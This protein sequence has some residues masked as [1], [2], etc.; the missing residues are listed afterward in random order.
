M[1]DEL[2]GLIKIE[3]YETSDNKFRID[4]NGMVLVD[5]NVYNELETRKDVQNPASEGL[6]FLSSIKW[7]GTT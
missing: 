3:Y 4:I 5:H 2:S 6:D 1:V 7:K